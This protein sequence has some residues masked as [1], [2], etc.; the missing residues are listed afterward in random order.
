M[1]IEIRIRIF[2]IFIILIIFEHFMGVWG[3]LLGLP[4]FMFLLDILGIRIQ[5]NKVNS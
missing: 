3:L 1:A 2:I 4:L 5:Q